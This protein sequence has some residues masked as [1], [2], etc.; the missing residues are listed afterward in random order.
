MEL[1]RTL[2]F[3]LTVIGYRVG[4]CLF[5][6]ERFSGHYPNHITSMQHSKSKS[7]DDVSFYQSFVS[8]YHAV[9]KKQKLLYAVQSIRS[10][11]TSF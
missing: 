7:F 6:N 9:E 2:F 11:I 5:D 3:V 1:M 4:E 8:S 10:N